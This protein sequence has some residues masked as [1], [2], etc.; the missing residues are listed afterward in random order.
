MHSPDAVRSAD[1]AAVAVLPRAARLDAVD[2]LR[3]LVMIAMAL[4]HTRAYFHSGAIHGHDPLN[5]ASTSYPVFLTR[6]ITHFCAPVFIFLAGTGA[7]LSQTRGRTRRELSWFLVTRGAWLIAL[8]LTLVHWFGWAFQVNTHLFLGIVL[9]ALGW[10]MVA[11]AAL[12]HLPLAALAT[13]SLALIVGHN[14]LDG[15]APASWGGA[16]W[17]WQVL[18][19]GGPIA[20]G[21]DVTLWVGYPL[22]PWI[23]VMGAGYAFGQLLQRDR[24]ARR[25]LVFRIGLAAALAFVALRFANVYGDPRPWSAQPRAGF[26][27]LS[28]LD[29]TKYPPSLC[30]VLMTLG[31]ALMLLAWL[32]REPAP[33]ALRPAIVFGR[34]PMFYYLLHIPLIHA[35]AL[36]IETLRFGAA[37]W[38][39]GLPFGPL[40]TP[41]PATAGFSLPV[42]YLAWLAIVAALYPLCRWFADVKRRRRDAWL[43]YV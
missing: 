38:L 33:A 6:W 13:F 3:G 8:D 19:A 40:Q 36:A 16:A 11:L 37:P 23:G 10:S 18:H 43:S 34:V 26:T 39:I 30:Y 5:L 20:L 42:V 32:D 28:F 24:A 31:P 27:L 9:W 29:C 2:L 22:I 35:T 1:V 25:R 7:F 41:R 17:L 14:A 4:D 21:P 12:V 15:I